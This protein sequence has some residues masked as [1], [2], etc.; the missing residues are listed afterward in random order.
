M[1]SLS[2]DI[3]QELKQTISYLIQ[4]FLYYKKTKMGLIFFQ[5]CGKMFTSVHLPIG[6]TNKQTNK[7]QICVLNEVLLLV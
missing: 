5:F 2:A 4:V 1:Y 6:Q 7:K 3:Y